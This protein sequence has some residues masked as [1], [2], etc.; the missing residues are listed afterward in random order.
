MGSLF[1]S[2]WLADFRSKAEWDR[3]TTQFNAA[4]SVYD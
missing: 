1:P 4:F 2:I 3:Y